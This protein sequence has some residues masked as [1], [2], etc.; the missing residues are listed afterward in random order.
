MPI[1]ESFGDCKHFTISDL[2]VALGFIKERRLKGDWMPK[3]VYII[4]FLQDYSTSGVF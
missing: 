2:I 3:R 4:A 1:F